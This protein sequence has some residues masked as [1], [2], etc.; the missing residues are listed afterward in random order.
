MAVLVVLNVGQVAAVFG[1]YKQ[2]HECRPPLMYEGPPGV[3]EYFMH[4]EIE[5]VPELD[6]KLNWG[7]LPRFTIGDGS[8]YDIHYQAYL[9]AQQP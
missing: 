7:A 2:N 5:E 4:E 9:A 3:D 8:A 1:P 6:I